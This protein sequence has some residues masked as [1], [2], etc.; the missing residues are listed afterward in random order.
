MTSFSIAFLITAKISDAEEGFL[1]GPDGNAYKLIDCATEIDG[2]DPDK[3]FSVGSI[4]W[5]TARS[6]AQN[7]TFN[8]YPCDLASPSTQIVNNF[9]K[10][11][12]GFS[13]ACNDCSQFDFELCAWFGG[14]D[15]TLTEPPGPFQFVNDTDNNIPCPFAG[16]CVPVVLPGIDTDLTFQDWCRVSTG[17]G[18]NEPNGTTF[19]DGQFYLTYLR[20]PN[21]PGEPVGWADCKDFNCVNRNCT[22]NSYFVQCEV[23]PRNVPTLSELG[24]IALV[25]V[26]GIVGLLAIKRKQVR[27]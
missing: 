14:I 25:G 15:P 20:W 13:E 7:M 3:C 5:S 17:C 2:N 6:K 24:L 4:S 22:P 10:N 12:P 8:G 23:P 1:I 11:F 9:L 27:A 18:G 19:L 21:N 16:D 26:L